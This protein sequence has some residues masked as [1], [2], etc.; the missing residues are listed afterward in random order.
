MMLRKSSLRSRM[1]WIKDALALRML[2]PH[3]KL[4]FTLKYGDIASY[5]TP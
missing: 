5:E 4:P 2:Q 1:C 3:D